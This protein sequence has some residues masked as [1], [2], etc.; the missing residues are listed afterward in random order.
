ML[1]VGRDHRISRWTEVE[2]QG[3]VIAGVRPREGPA[4]PATSDE[5]IA[6]AFWDLQVNGRRGVSF[7]SP[8]LNVEQV[9]D[10]V[11]AQA[12]LGTARLCPTVITA[13][14]EAMI[15]GLRTIAAACEEYTDVARM[16]LGIHLEGPFLSQCEGFRGA[17]PKDAIRDPDWCLFEEFQMASGGR[18][19][20]VTLAPERPGAIDFIERAVAAGVTVA[21]GHT[22]AS[23]ETIRQAVEAGAKLSTHLGNGIAA[24]LP[25]HPNP[26]WHQ[27][28]EDS[29]FASFISDGDH[30]D[31][32]T[33][34]VLARA[35]G[36]DR[37]ILVSDASPLS[38]LP[39][40]TFG[41]WEIE[42]SGRIV[43]AGT[44]YLAGSSQPLEIG[45]RNLM[46]ATSWPLSETL[47]T[48]TKNAA[49]LL[50]QPCPKLEPG[51]PAN[52]VVFRLDETGR[53]V[54]AR[55]CV[56]GTWHEAARGG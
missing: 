13:P 54:L 53:F 42:P 19:V 2:I 3:R 46:A 34:R 32:D 35:K 23:G 5:F 36:P 8:D 48:V 51:E 12:P 47:A 7:S 27:A 37:T 21:L 29:L 33:L 56:G 17:H 28:A 49:V 44:S 52:V 55:T 14:R 9:A 20:L 22:A 26:I 6:P 4:K 1:I 45:L 50:G 43:V 41:D 39:A 11:G 31:R 40:G 25:R 30:L 24:L 10:I 15:H 18:I 38:G 16:L